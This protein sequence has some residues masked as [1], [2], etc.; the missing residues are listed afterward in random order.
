MIPE[1]KSNMLLAARLNY[2]LRVILPTH[3]IMEYIEMTDSQLFWL[4]TII[5][6]L[7]ITTKTFS[8]YESFIIS[9]FHFFN[10]SNVIK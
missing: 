1:C 9:L 10:I 3:S 6:F 4:V 5:Y 2:S 7:S 8:T